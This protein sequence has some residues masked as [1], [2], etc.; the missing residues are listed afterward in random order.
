MTRLRPFLSALLILLVALAA[1]GEGARGIRTAG[2]MEVT[3]CDGMGGMTT[4]RVDHRGEMVP[5]P[6]D[7]PDCRDWFAAVLPP[8]LLLPSAPDSHG[9]P[10]ALAAGR[11]VHAQDVPHPSA[12]APPA[13]I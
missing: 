3:L 4:I 10:L 8:A 6:D 7:C 2:A 12:R 11:P 9:R 5:I 13:L 1:G